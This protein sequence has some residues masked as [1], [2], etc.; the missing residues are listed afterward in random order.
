MANVELLTLQRLELPVDPPLVNARGAWQRRSTLIVQLHDAQGRHGHGEAAPLPNFSTDSL[1]ACEHA[2]RTIPPARLAALSGVTS[3]RALLDAAAELLPDDVPA[4]RFALETALLDRLGRRSGQPLWKLIAEALPPTLAGPSSPIE[5]CALLPSR[6]PDAAISE[7]RRCRRAGVKT[8]K[9]KIGP[10]RVGPTQLATLTAL[11]SALDPGI[12]LRL[13]A[14][15]S[16]SPEELHSTLR[17]LA[18]F[19]PEL[20]EEPLAELDLEAYTGSHCPLALDESL[21]TLDPASVDA[22]LGLATGQALVLK[23]TALGGFARCMNFAARSV[24]LGRRVIVSHSLEGPIAWSACAHLALALRQPGAAGLWPL[25][26]QRAE[27]PRVVGGLLMPSD[28][29][30]LGALA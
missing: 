23:P 4:A 2:L 5:L 19:Q 12:A 8:F 15:G 20:V 7:A 13:D 22:F 1:P 24:L 26:H 3:P 17:Q 18:A 10:T 25:R 29:A 27:S 28:A 30:G 14:N 9:L 21:Q 11:R 16:L 6:G